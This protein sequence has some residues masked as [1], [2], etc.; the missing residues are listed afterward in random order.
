MLTWIKICSQVRI[1]NL[2][3]AVRPLPT[4]QRVPELDEWQW[5]HIPGHAPGH[6]S[7]F[8]EKDRLLLSSDAFITVRQD[9]F[10]NV[11]MQKK[12]VNGPPRYLT[13]DWEAAWN[14]VKK[15]AALQPEIVVSGHGQ[16][17]EGEELKEG[18]SRLAQDFQKLV[19]PDY[20]R[21]VNG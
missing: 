16:S 10:Y 17:M 3:Q 11:L 1:I 6:V 15:L 7:F 4:D 9:S 19:I 8:R 12:E 2:G 5:I 20:G 21:Y 18:L 14:S 13:K